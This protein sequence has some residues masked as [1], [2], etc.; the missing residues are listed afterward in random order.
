M[1]VFPPNS[2]HFHDTPHGDWRACICLPACCTLD[3]GSDIDTSA[4]IKVHPLSTVN[5]VHA[6]MNSIL[7]CTTLLS[8]IAI[9]VT[10]DKQTLYS[11]D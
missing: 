3:I 8:T 10:L 5:L 11:N 1:I 7:F 2:S 6:I 9:L 4:H